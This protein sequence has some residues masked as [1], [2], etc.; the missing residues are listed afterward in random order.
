M[1]L[2]EVPAVIKRGLRFR[3]VEHMEDVIAH[4]LLPVTVDSELVAAE[5]RGEPEA[6]DVEATQV[7]S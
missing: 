6:A 7:P 4:A 2:E 3:F 1:S 5:R